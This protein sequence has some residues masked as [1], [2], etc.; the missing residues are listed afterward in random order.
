MTGPAALSR[1]FLVRCFCGAASVGYSLLLADVLAVADMGR[2]AATVSVAVIAATVAK[3]GLDA[4]LL[5]TAATHP[6]GA[7]PIT[8]RCLAFAGLAGAVFWAVGGGAP[9]ET[10]SAYAAAFRVF[11]AGVPF[12]AMGFVLAGLLKAASRPAAALLLEMGGWQTV[13]CLCAI[14]MRQTGSDS[15]LLVAVCFAVGPTLLFAGFFLMSERL[16]FSRAVSPDPRS[17]PSSRIQLRNVAPFA[18]VSICHV[19]IRWSDALWLA[20]WLDVEAVAIYVVCTRLAGGIS[21]VDHAVNAL[22]APRFA[23]YHASRNTKA[24]RTD[25]RRVCMTSCGLGALGATAL[26]SLA[27]IILGFFGAPY[28]ESAGLLQ[29]AAV[30][31][32]VHVTL[33]PVGHLAAMSGRAIDHFKASGVMLLLQQAIYLLAIPRFGMAGALLGFALPQVF[34]NLLTLA[35]LLRRGVFDSPVR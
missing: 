33:V 2:F 8:V 18:A 19:L 11:L 14:L 30:L 7:R 21:F 20:F 22:A 12:L 1:T 32:A 17:P 13:M 9:I 29:T 6:Q 35:L 4:Y 15:L 34:A 23:R 28:A 5:R 10:G 24:L 25:F 27:P 3:C 16:I 26:I 31:M